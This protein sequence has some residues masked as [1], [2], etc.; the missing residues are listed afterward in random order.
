MKKIIFNIPRNPNI[1]ITG[2]DLGTVSHI[3]GDYY[4]EEKHVVYVQN[5]LIYLNVRYEHT[6]NDCTNYCKIYLEVISEYVVMPEL[7]A[8]INSDDKVEIN[9]IADY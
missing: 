1:K 6:D 4:D 8:K 3:H 7:D 9:L 5:R 2:I